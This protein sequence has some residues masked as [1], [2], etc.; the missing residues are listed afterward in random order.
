MSVGSYFNV[1]VAICKLCTSPV[2]LR[3]SYIELS[4]STMCADALE[5]EWS[6][7]KD[8]Y[9]TSV[10]FGQHFGDWKISS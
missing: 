4:V 7:S 3:P 9:S 1:S 8:R 6:I 5:L 2:E 10:L